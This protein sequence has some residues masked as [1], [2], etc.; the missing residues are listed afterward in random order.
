MKT[1]LFP[2]RIDQD[3][4]T[5]YAKAMD[6]AKQIGAKV[7][8]FTSLP[9]AN[10]ATKDKAYFHLLELYG[11][12]QSMHNNWQAIPKVI[13]K[14]V[15]V[16]GDFKQALQNLQRCTAIDWVV[17]TAAF[18]NDCNGHQAP[19]SNLALVRPR[20]ACYPNLSVEN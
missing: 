1:I 5:A 12:Y 10:S 13:S 6:M 11:Y 9:N 20:M 4:K 2:F 19:T 8:F 17:P 7:I 18:T 14:R 16:V 3:N 15:F